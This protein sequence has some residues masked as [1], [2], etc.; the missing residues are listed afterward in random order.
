MSI[1]FAKKMHIF[2]DFPQTFP[3]PAGRALGNPAVSLMLKD[4]PAAALHAKQVYQ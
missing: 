2:S 1:P 3:A 4:V